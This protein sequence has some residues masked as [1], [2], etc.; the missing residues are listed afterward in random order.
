MDNKEYEPFVENSQAIESMR[1]S[2]FSIYSAIAEIVDNS[3]EAESELINIFYDF[4]PKDKIMHNI[5]VSDNGSG[6]DIDTLWKCL[7][8]GWSTRY[9]NRNGIGRFG[10]G[11]TLAA[12][13]QCSKITVLSKQKG[14][15]AQ[16]VE[17]NLDDIHEG[18]SEGL[19]KPKPLR[20]EEQKRFSK[21]IPKSSGTVVIWEVFDRFD[22]DDFDD[23]ELRFFLS[24]TYRNWLKNE[25]GIEL[26]VNDKEILQHDPL[27]RKNK[28]KSRLRFPD[29]PV[30]VELEEIPFKFPIP[31][32]VAIKDR[33][34][35]T[36][37]EV[38]ITMSLLPKEWR[39]TKGKGGRYN[40][41]DPETEKFKERYLDRNEGVSFLRNGR[42]VHYDHIKYYKPQFKEIDRWWACEIDFPPLLDKCFTVK[43]IKLGVRPNKSLKDCIK[44]KIEPTRNR[45]LDIIRADWSEIK[46]EKSSGDSPHSESTKA[47]K[48]AIDKQKR[49]GP[50]KLSSSLTDEE[51]KKTE[52]ELKDR[53]W[54]E[55][56]DEER[57]ALLTKFET[58]PYEIVEISFPSEVNIFMHVS[59]MRKTTVLQYNVMHPFFKK[60]YTRLKSVSENNPKAKDLLSCLDVLLISYANARSQ[61]DSNARVKLD[62]ENE[63]YIGDFFSEFHT[64]WGNFL[65]SYIQ[66]LKDEN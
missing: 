34:G 58:K 48:D 47:V 3:I 60:F 11:M 63:V 14:K 64:N 32:D 36:E 41:D 5:I 38:K 46:D 37:A 61:Y 25:S 9:N 54:K 1:H 21:Y 26:S 56:T 2:N 39:E 8:L 53:L 10:V 62:S 22:G 52:Q 33:N 44:E 19:E 6:M 66:E 13:S 12:I 29:D 35:A 23:E 20:K 31:S 30:A 7:K 43:N 27:F 24:R 18:E 17:L 65:K 42:E 51:K 57:A 15:D 4:S 59:F 28:D 55:K 45:F 40:K 16:K 49:I 50:G